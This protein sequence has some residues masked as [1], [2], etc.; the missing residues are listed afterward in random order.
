VNRYVL[1]LAGVVVGALL[2]AAYLVGTMRASSEPEPAVVPLDLPAYCHHRFGEGSTAI[3]SPAPVRMRCSAVLN[4]V[5][6]LEVVDLDDAC[7]WQQ[8]DGAH[9]IVERPG[10]GAGSGEVEVR[11]RA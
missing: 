3:A 10:A 1:A 6:G 7:R 11:C 4:G 5:W 8:G 9:F 2:A